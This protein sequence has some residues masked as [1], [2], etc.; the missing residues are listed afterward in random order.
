MVRLQ[1]DGV[2]WVGRLWSLR[3]SRIVPDRL[4]TQVDKLWEEQ[5]YAELETACEKKNSPLA[6]TLAGIVKH[7]H[8]DFHTVSTIAGDIAS[9]EMRRHLQK[10]FPVVIVAT[11]EP[12]LF[13]IT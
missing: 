4:L 13:Q 11:L 1:Q 12:L 2:Q 8:A 10:L 7:R 6:R 9:R 5:K 3:R